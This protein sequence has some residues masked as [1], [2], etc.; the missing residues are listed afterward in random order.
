VRY[1][2]I[3]TH[4]DEFEVQLMC[5]VLEVSRS[6]YYA[7]RTRE[8]SQ[9][10]MADHDFLELIKTVFA[11]SR[12]TYGYERVWKEL[13][14]REIAC[15][16]HRVRR[17]MRQ[18]RLLPRQVK[19][20]KRTTRANPNHQAAPNRLEQDFTATQPNSKW[21]GDITYVPTAAGWLYLAV[22]IDLFS[23]RIIGWAMSSRMTCELVCDAFS[24]AVRQ[25]QPEAGLIFHSDRG[26][27]Y[28][29]SDFQTLLARH[30]TLASMSGTGNCYDNA[31]AE[32]FFGT[33]K[34]ELVHHAVYQTRPQAELDIF[35]YM[36]GFYNC[37]RRH[38][39]LGHLSPVTFEAE[40]AQIIV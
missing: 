33:L 3:E 2:F 30:G 38:S 8:P 25:R 4:R 13:R 24:M 35:F 21:V 9:R 11:E 18:A 12:E 6:G 37:A 34:S 20:Y 10:E 29:S 16:K 40:H 15:G 22:I 19:R 26:S 7:W 14:S 27:Q 36:E 32:S 39:T 23:R 1:R 31:V 28:T 17:L 5:E